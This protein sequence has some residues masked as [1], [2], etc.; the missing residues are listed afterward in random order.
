MLSWMDLQPGRPLRVSLILLWKSLLAGDA[1]KNKTL[2]CG[3][4]HVS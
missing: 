2:I 1:P 3:G 4:L